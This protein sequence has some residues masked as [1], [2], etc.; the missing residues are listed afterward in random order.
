M[1][2]AK[3]RWGGLTTGA[4]VLLLALGGLTACSAGDSPGAENTPIS[5]DAATSATPSAPPSE[6]PTETP[7]ATPTPSLVVTTDHVGQTSD[8]AISELTRQGL[9]LSFVDTAGRALSS[10]Q[11]W[12]VVAQ[13]P[14]GG[15]SV[16]AGSWVR[17]TLSPPVVTADHVGETSDQ[18]ISELTQQG[19]LLSF[20]DSSGQAISSQKG[21]S[22]VG[23]NPPAGVSV[24][25]GSWVQLVLSPP[26]PPPPPADTGSGSG[27]GS[28]SGSGS[29]QA[30]SPGGGPTALCNDGTLSHSAHHQGTC[31]HHH[32]VAVWYK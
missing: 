9:L 26:P 28:S 3:R 23:Q 2:H 17:L 16:E 22:V 24:R 18:A 20:V 15:A 19:L 12:S 7:S 14:P 31:S 32:G 5:Q 30:V 13:S 4:V 29:E 11:G 27:S 1:A 8:E 10:Q 21:W 6:T 25:A